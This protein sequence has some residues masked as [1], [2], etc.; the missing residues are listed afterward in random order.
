MLEPDGVADKLQNAKRQLE[1]RLGVGGRDLTQGV[2]RAGRRLPRRVRR[3]AAV[4]VATE[5]MAGNPKLVRRVEPAA[6]DRAYEGLLRHLQGIDPAD[7][8]RGRVIAIA[9]GV[10][11]NLLVV[12]VCFITWLWWRGYV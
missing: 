4:L 3:Q 5:R 11:F 2:Q 8:R 1:V 12:I 10:A 9:A 7:R 6:F